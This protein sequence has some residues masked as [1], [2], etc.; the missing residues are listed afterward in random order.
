MARAPKMASGKIS[1]ARGI[2]RCPNVFISLARPTF[3]YCEAYVC[4]YTYLTV[5]RLYMNYRCNQIILRVKLFYTSKECCEVLTG[6]LSLGRRPGGDWT[7][8]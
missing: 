6:Y 1:L 4:I 7:N 8:V 5:N 2:H 3:L